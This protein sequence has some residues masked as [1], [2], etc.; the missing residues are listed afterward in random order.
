[1]GLLKEEMR[2]LGSLIMAAAE[3][4]RVPAGKALAVDREAFAAQIT[5][6][7]EP[8]PWW[9]SCGEEVTGPGPDRHHG[10]GHRAPDLGGPGR[11]PGP[12]H[13]PGASAF[14]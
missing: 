2:R 6:A 5:Q 3:A 4:T 11:G 10:H 7:L 12:P 1:M 8:S 13:R 14:L 9:R